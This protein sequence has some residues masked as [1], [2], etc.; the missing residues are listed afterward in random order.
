MRYLQSGLLLRPPARLDRNYDSAG[1]VWVSIRSRENI[2]LRHARDG[3]WHFPGE[4]PWGT[5]EDIVRA[6]L[7]AADELPRGDEGI[8]LID[9]SSIAVTFFSE[10]E[11]CSVGQLDNDK[12][13]IVVC[14]RERRSRMGGALPRMPGISNE[15]EQF[16]HARRKNG[17]LVS[18]EPFIIYRHQV[19]KAVEPDAAWQPTGVPLEVQSL[20]HEDPAICGLGAGRARDLALA[21]MFAIA[22][23][24]APLGDDLCPKDLDS[25]YVTVYV[26][27][28]LRGCMGSVVKNLDADIRKLTLAALQ[29]RRFGDE[30]TEGEPDDVAVTV[31]FLFSPLELGAY[32]PEEVALRVRQGRHALM[33]Y[34]NNRVG[35]LLPFVAVTNN[36]DRSEFI[37]EVIDKA[38]I[39]RPPY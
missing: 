31:S 30:P 33:V 11:E 23:T 36:L 18:F 25:I 16:Q 28:H 5:A 37:A 24:T 27:G 12:Y 1:G 13:G 26:R 7:R 22:E 3:F 15:W 38:G 35:L 9:D 20:W 34:Q 21:G 8:R 17:E 10:L 39:T 6:C 14:S 19:T 32:A 2:Y 29:D 4:D